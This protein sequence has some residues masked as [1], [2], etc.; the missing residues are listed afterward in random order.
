L[1]GGQG[2]NAVE[3]EQHLAERG[4]EPAQCAASAT[5]AAVVCSDHLHGA[6]TVKDQGG[7]ATAVQTAEAPATAGACTT[8]AAP[9]VAD[10]QVVVQLPGGPCLGSSLDVVCKATGQQDEGQK[11]F[12]VTE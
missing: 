6:Q 1:G 3:Q 5:A 7:A 12:I 9:A 11:Q 4:A 10:G 8:P 2:T